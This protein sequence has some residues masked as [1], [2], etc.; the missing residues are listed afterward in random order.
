[1]K[2]KSLALAGIALSLVA[3]PGTALAKNGDAAS[4]EVILHIEANGIVPPDRVVLTVPFEAVGAT[5]EA[6]LAELRQKQES[7][8]RQLTGSG[9]VAD[10][11]V[12]EPPK[13]QNNGRVSVV[14]YEAGMAAEEAA[15]PAAVSTARGRSVAKPKPLVGVESD[16]TVSLND[17][18][19][20]DAVQTAAAENGVQS[21]RLYNSA[22]FTTSDP[23][24]A[25]SKARDQAIAKARAEADAHAASLGYR[26]VRMTKVSNSAPPFSLLDVWRM[27]NIVDF[28]ATRFQP[29]Y[30]AGITP[31]TVAI[32][33]VIVP[34]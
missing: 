8:V 15:A 12:T 16:I 10:R 11:I 28:N 19:K 32:D 29:S 9:I 18:S 6:A 24:A 22:R 23:I 2:P 1:M 26:V 7:F 5:R 25:A 4:N 30:Y 31:A 21:Y 17:L 13:D 3:L 33:F 34:K 14:A 27:M 20:L